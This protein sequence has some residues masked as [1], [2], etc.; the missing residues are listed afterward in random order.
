MPC[1]AFPLRRERTLAIDGPQRQH[2]TQSAERVL[3]AAFGIQAASRI[4]AEHQR[5]AA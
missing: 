2:K 3:H 4:T 5:R 1:S